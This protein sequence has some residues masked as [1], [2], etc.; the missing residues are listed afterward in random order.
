[1]LFLD[2]KQHFAPFKV[3]STQDITKWNPDFDTRRLVEWQNKNYIRRIIN[4]WYMFVEPLDLDTMY[5]VS[6]R[7]YAPSYISFESAL[8]YYQLIPEAVFSLTAATTLTTKTFDT[9]IGQ[10]RYRHIK[11]KM[12]FGYKLIEADGVLIKM[13]E[14]EKMLVDYLYLN[15]RITTPEHFEGLRI[16]AVELDRILNRQRLQEYVEIVGNRQLGKRIGEFMK[17]VLGHA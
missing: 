11:P 17:T 7:I 15:S 3:F 13:V 6:N 1:M 10:F 8:A 12:M 14:P 16:N 2:F 9:A 5:L 4:R